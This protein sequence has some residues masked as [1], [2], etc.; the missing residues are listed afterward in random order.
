MLR[1]LVST[2]PPPKRGSHGVALLIKESGFT[3]IPKFFNSPLG[4]KLPIDRELL[5]H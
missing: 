4:E 2:A 3:V 1:Y 5:Y